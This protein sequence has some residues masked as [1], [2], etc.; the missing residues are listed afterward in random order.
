M[1]LFYTVAEFRR[2]RWQNPVSTWGFVPTMGFL[3]QGHLSLVTQSKAEN[4]RTAVSIFV[5]PTQFAPT[6]D[7]ASYPRD[8]E[9]DLAM[10]VEAG[11]DAVFVPSVAE[12]YPP[13]YQTFVTVERVSQGLEG[14]SRPTHF[15]GVATIVTKL[16]NIAQ[17]QRAYFGQKDAQQV[18]VIRQLVADL[19][20]NTEIIVC[21]TFREADGLAMS[22][23]NSYLLNHE[24]VA[25]TVLFRALQTGRALLNSGVRD[26]NVIKEG[27]RGILSAEPL[28]QVEY[29]SVADPH[30]LQTLETVT[31]RALLS[32]AVKIGRPRLIDNLLWEE[33]R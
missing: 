11:V 13:N 1:E 24:R 5:N 3:H 16:L 10:L 2:W 33:E 28:A 31:T 27:M 21:P 15:R 29:L 19:Q 25:A 20:I 23:R 9:R 8:L 18:A 14:G 26:V 6:E 22:S 32:L 17:P 30:T 7:L 12:M 4:E